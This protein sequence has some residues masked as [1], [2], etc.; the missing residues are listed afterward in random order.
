[1]VD[2]HERE[3]RY[4]GNEKVFKKL[5]IRLPMS[6]VFAE[7]K[8]SHVLLDLLWLTDLGRISGVLEEAVNTHHA[9][10]SDGGV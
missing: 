2:G 1:L 7:E 10:S 3:D 8:C 4:E 6:V 9:E 5:K